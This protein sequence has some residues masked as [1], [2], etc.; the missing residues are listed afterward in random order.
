MSAFGGTRKLPAA[1]WSLETLQ[2]FLLLR[3]RSR[4]RYAP[5]LQ[6]ISAGWLV[7]KDQVF[8]RTNLVSRSIGWA[9]AYIALF[10]RRGTFRDAL[11]VSAR[12]LGDQE[13]AVAGRY[14]QMQPSVEVVESHKHD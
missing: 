2:D 14:L 4:D 13:I 5:A 10:C 7:G 1:V 6:R 8:D 11:A 12:K 3:K 9:T